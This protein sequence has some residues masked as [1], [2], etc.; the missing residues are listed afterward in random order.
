MESSSF[1]L[2]KIF[3]F[4]VTY[5]MY[6]ANIAYF[7]ASG[8]GVL[9]MSSSVLGSYVAV[10]SISTALLPAMIGYIFVDSN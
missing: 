8:V 10:V 7:C 9:T 5:G 6:T 1:P 2:Q 4:Y 3:L